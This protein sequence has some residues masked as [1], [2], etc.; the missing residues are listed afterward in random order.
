MSGETGHVVGERSCSTGDRRFDLTSTGER[1]TLQTDD[2]SI[3]RSSGTTAKTQTIADAKAITKRQDSIGT[4]N[5]STAAEIHDRAG[6]NRNAGNRG[7]VGLAR[8]TVAEDDGRTFGIQFSRS[9]IDLT[10]LVRRPGNSLGDGGTTVGDEF[11][12]AGDETIVVVDGVV[13]LI[14]RGDKHGSQHVSVAGGGH[15]AVV[16]IKVSSRGRLCHLL[17]LSLVVSADCRHL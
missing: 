17:I 10:A 8:T 2:L 1:L 9:Q 12:T 15:L 4:G 14:P 7:G 5:R 6:D 16:H 13:D 11:T 3:H